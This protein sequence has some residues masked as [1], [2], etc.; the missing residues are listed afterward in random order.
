[1]PKQ[2]FVITLNSSHAVKNGSYITS[3]VYPFISGSF[4]ILD[5]DEMCV[6]Q[7]TLPY[8][9]FNVDNG[10]YQNA[11]FQII[12]TIGATPTTY[13]ITL[14]NGFYSVDDI[15]NYLEI[16]CI[17][18]GL[19]LVN[20]SSQ[21][22]YYIT[23]QTNVTYY[24]VQLTCFNVPTSL[25]VGWTQPINFAGYPTVSSTPQFVVTQ[26]NFGYLI[27]FSSGTYPSVVQATP[28][29]V[30][31]T[32]VPNATPVNS[33][34]IRCS[35]VYNPVQAPSDILDSMP[36]TSTFGSNINYNPTF[37]K[38]V[39]VR[40]GSYSSLVVEFLDQNL[41]PVPLRDPNALISLLLVS[42]K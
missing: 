24:G 41:N 39:K 22:V 33:Y 37:E 40:S 12:W 30:L 21:N 29:T 2:N 8:S 9:N 7:I 25:P 14:P 4:K 20:S 34:I 18:N 15:Q 32:L 13:N 27:G 42:G 1:M 10:F 35:L 19:Y 3:F 31:S 26:P 5:G 11:Q 17:Q 38:L 36:I 16:F 28:F 23:L 6:S